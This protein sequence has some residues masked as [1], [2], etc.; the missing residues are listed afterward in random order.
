MEELLND[1]NEKLWQLQAEM[2]QLTATERALQEK[3]ADFA[4]VDRKYNA[5]KNEI[6]TL[7]TRLDE[8]SKKRRDS[9]RDLGTEQELLR[10]YQGQLMQVKNQQQYA[11]VWKEIDT[12]RKKVSELEDETLKGMEEIGDIEKS[13]EEKRA[14]HETLQLEHDRAHAEWQESLGELRGKAEELRGRV[15]ALEKTIPDG[16]RREFHQIFKNRQGI[17]VARVDE[18]SCSGCRVRI[19][20][21]VIQQLKRG[22]ISHCEGCRRILYMERTSAVS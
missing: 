11:A 19:R 18:G 13:L 2:A 21:F 6:E 22:E 1:T 5:S 4:E 8:I 15:A 12:Q 14:E 16:L 7:Q 3:P 20:P 10:K 9:E 17:A